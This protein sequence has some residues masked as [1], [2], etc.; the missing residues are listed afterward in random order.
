MVLHYAP[1][2]V[3]MVDCAGVKVV[4]YDQTGGEVVMTMG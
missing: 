3:A 2:E 1:G 4:I